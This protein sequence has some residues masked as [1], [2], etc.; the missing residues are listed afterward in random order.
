MEPPIGRGV[1]PQE[2]AGRGRALPPALRGCGRHRQLDA[3]YTQVQICI[4]RVYI[5]I[6]SVEAY[7]NEFE[8][9]YILWTAYYLYLL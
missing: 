4:L 6:L 7:I 5:W 1:S 3:G 8:F 2:S 9:L